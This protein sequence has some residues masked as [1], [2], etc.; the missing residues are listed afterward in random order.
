LSSGSRSQGP[1]LHMQ[2]ILGRRNISNHWVSCWKLKQDTQ[3]QA[4]LGLLD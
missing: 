1:C 3:Q 4:L 2:S